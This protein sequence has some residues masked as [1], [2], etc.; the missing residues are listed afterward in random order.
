[1]IHSPTQD[2][3]KKGEKGKGEPDLM[4][5]IIYSLESGYIVEI[6]RLKWVKNKNCLTEMAAYLSSDSLLL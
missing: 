3:N 1:L 6:Q 4:M 2:Q 5:R